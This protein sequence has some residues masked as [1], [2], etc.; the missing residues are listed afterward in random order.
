MLR[1]VGQFELFTA[2]QWTK[3]ELGAVATSQ[4]LNVESL[5]L[6]LACF[7]YVSVVECRAG[8]CHHPARAARAGTPVRL[9]VLI[10][11]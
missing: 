11:S 4:R 5:I 3:S 8:R 6:A 9:P 7:H 1:V 2:D 10:L